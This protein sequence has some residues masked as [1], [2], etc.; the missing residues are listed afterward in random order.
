MSVE[1]AVIANQSIVQITQ[2]KV[3]QHPSRP[4]TTVIV[5]EYQ[6]LKEA[7]DLCFDLWFI[8]VQNEFGVYQMT[9]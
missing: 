4:T 3:F 2:E 8:Q 1:M 9:L 7:C 6:E 5:V